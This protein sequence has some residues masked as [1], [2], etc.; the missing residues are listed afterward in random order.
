M[1]LRPRGNAVIASA[2]I[3]LP[4][5]LFCL[6]L[7]Y[8][9]GSIPFG[10]IITRLAGLGDVRQIG[11]GNIGA[12]N[13]LRTGN[14]WAAALTLLLDGGKGAVAVLIAYMFYGTEGGV[15]AGIAA[16]MG[17]I[18]PVWLRFKGGKGVATFIG[19]MLAAYWPAGLL[20]IATWL[21]VAYFSKISSLSALIAAALA[22]AYT[23]ALGNLPY[24]VLAFVLAIIIFITHHE[25][26][27]RLW[28][29]E[30][31]RIGGKKNGG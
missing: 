9:L 11:S 20:V 7:G 26:I 22:P 15:A 24:A 31:P 25:N 29:G 19:V 21:I 2:P 12:T 27:H 30:E 5:A 18:F 14:K 4:E 6:A 13:V 16:I 23:I 1:R 8:L 17:H 10:L 28:R 3:D